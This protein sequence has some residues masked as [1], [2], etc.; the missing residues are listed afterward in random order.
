MDMRAQSSA[1]ACTS[2]GTSRAAHRNVLATARSSPKLGSVTRTP[3]ISSRRDRNKSAQARASVRVSTD[4]WGVASDDSATARSPPR[5]S[6]SSMSVRPVEQRC[7]GKNPRFPTMTPRVVGRVIMC[8]R[9]P[10]V[11]RAAGPGY[12]ITPNQAV[13]GSRERLRRPELCYAG[14]PVTCP[15]DERSS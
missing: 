12:V 13:K 14:R 2:T 8:A 9:S 5:S 11:R 10:A 7:E 15:A 6:A 4:P 1:N 3:S